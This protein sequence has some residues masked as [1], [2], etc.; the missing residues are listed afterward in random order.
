[1]KFC[2]N[3]GAKLEDNISFCEECG[4]KQPVKE[5]PKQNVI[6]SRDLEPLTEIR[7]ESNVEKVEP[8]VNDRDNF[9]RPKL[10]EACTPASREIKS[11]VMILLL[12]L[13]SP[14][15]MMV[16]PV[17]IVRHISD[18]VLF[19]MH[20]FALGIMWKK[21]NWSIVIKLVVIGIYLLPYMLM[22]FI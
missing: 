4:A 1:M 10:S 17:S 13:F 3:C 19:A 8:I 6:A 22:F 15:M 5:Q 2:E 14:Y 11:W 12:I 16:L 9:V 7:D 20:L 21:C 18:T